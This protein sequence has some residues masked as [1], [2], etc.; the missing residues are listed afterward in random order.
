MT[1]CTCTQI[2]TTLQDNSETES[3]FCLDYETVR[4]APLYT[5]LRDIERCGKSNQ[6]HF[7][8][9]KTVVIDLWQLL[10]TSAWSVYRKYELL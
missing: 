10:V 2:R 4:L 1:R 5:N 7:N 8:S 9:R 3:C 6:G